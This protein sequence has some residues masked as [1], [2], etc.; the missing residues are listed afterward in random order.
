MADMRIK[1]CINEGYE[2][3]WCE[4]VWEEIDSLD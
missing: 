1:K 4:E 2:Q 3:Q